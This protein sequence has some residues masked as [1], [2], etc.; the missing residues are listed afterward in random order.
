MYVPWKREDAT[1]VLN[2]EWS[3]SLKIGS[4]CLPE[5]KRVDYLLSFA[6]IFVHSDLALPSLSV[7]QSISK[8]RTHTRT[9]TRTHTRTRTPKRKSITNNGGSHESTP[10]RYVLE[11]IRST[12]NRGS[13]R[14][15][16]HKYVEYIQPREWSDLPTYPC[17]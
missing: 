14:M 12:Y 15:S 1:S 6:S 3:S 4:S 7:L 16:P 17:S 9:Y 5:R 8:L 13:S 2:F 11:Y 10:N